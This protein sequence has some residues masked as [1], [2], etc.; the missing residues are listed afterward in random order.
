MDFRHYLARWGRAWDAFWFTPANPATLSLIRILAGGMLCY[1]HLVWWL[2]SQ[3]FFGRQGR[4]SAEFSR[5]YHDSP[6]AWSHLYGVEGWLGL[7]LSGLA[8]VLIFAMLTVGLCT[9]VVSVLA[10]LITVSYA[11][12]A[13]GALFGLDQIN[14]M[15]ALYL[16]VGPSGADFSVDQWRRRRKSKQAGEVPRSVL[17]NVAIRLIQVHMCVIYLFAGCGKLLGETWW[18]GT[19]LWGAFANYEYQTLDMT[20]TAHSILLINILTHVTVAWEISYAALVWPRLTRPIVIALA[21]PLHLGIAICMGMI[22]F[23]LVMIVGNLAFVPPELS[24][25]WLGALLGSRRPVPDREPVSDRTSG[26]RVTGHA[27]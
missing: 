6:Y 2:H 1:T 23:G 25:R 4:L 5:L 10:F 7:G 26:K 15:L 12:R 14:G 22:T 27:G 20:W 8:A 18:D 9:R 19:A 17:A 21:V 3:A 24:R 13:A 11:H 16:A